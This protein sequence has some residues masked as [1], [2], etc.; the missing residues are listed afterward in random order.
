MG[1][2][3]FVFAMI[4][5]NNFF[6]TTSYAARIAGVRSQ[7]LALANSFFAMISFASRTATFLYMPAIA[8]IAQQSIR[9]HFNPFYSFLFVILG[10]AA[11]TLGGLLF[12][13]AFEKFYELGIDRME[14]TGNVMG[15]F[16]SICLQK[17]GLQD[18]ARCWRPPRVRF[19][20]NVRLQGVP[21]DMIVLNVILYAFV[22][23]AP[24]AP[25]VAAALRP[26]VAVTVT[27]LS[28]AINSIGVF[29]L[30]FL[31]DP[32]GAILMDQGIQRKIP[33]QVV[34]SSMILLT[35]S[36]LVGTLLSLALLYPAAL[37]VAFL[38]RFY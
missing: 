3:W 6:D 15:V 31:V 24:I 25:Y 13:P 34:E 33:M 10:A 12:L 30:L 23:I 37:F 28:P 36:R 21:R 2:L 7:Q 11:G 4:A 16:K 1:Y 22:T 8:S 14:K 35:A 32:R 26:E 27:G 9:L 17:S 29:L 20:K 5:V 18:L 19:W 38:A